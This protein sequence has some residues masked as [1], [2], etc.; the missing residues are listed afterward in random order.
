MRNTVRSFVAAATVGSATLGASAQQAVQWRVEDGGNGHW[1]AFN[2]DLVQWSE[3]RQRAIARGGDLVSLES[4][5]EL[6]WFRNQAWC[7]SGLKIHLG[8][9][10][11]AAA[12]SLTS[13]WRWLT[14]SA[15]NLNI[16]FDMDD[17]PCT[18][19]CCVEDGEQNLL[20]LFAGCAALGDVNNG[21]TAN[22]PADRSAHA[23]VIEWSSDCNND[24]LVDYGQILN[25]Q[26]ADA[27]D[28]GVPDMCEM[29]SCAG[30]VIPDGAI[31]GVD[32]AAV[33]SAWGTTGQGQ[34]AADVN[35]DGTVNGTDLSYILGGWGNC[36]T[37]PA[38]G[39]LL[40]LTPDPTVVTDAGLRG[41]I[42]STGY[43]WRVRDTATQIEMV[44]IPPG[45]FSMGCSPSASFTCSQDE[46]P[47]H[48]VTITHPFYLA[49]Y[50]VTQSQWTSVMGSNPSQ[51]QSASVHVPASQVSNRPVE[52]I[53]WNMAQGFLSVTGVR[54]PTEAE[55]EYAC[56]A[57]TTTAFHGFPG[58]ATGS[59]DD[60]LAG[61]IAWF[62]ANAASQTRP[63]GQRLPNS[64]GLHDMAGN[65]WEWVNDWYSDTYYAASPGT[66]P[67]GP[68]SGT[69]KVVRGASW[70]NQSDGCRSSD[71]YFIQPTSVDSRIGFR[72]ARN[73]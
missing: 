56:R 1:Y 21:P 32:L 7:A 18:Q 70:F 53:S 9:V 38:W 45:T 58:Y 64:L 62:S 6:N 16:P 15:V 14:G 46:L 66:N 29:P 26:L 36:I 52:R 61:A 44:L 33:L 11:D 55:W 19:G 42:A 40:E 13:G 17:S 57:G 49:R 5:A 68:V 63:V 22:C 24:G 69:H 2:A 28:N 30:D 10:Q 41:A 54:L 71:R 60:T 20:H 43:A 39:T 25:G 47:V 37:V 27:N 59:N 73:P 31:D 23:Y 48:S 67:F 12:S 3:A 50:E 51:F 4:S 35:R 72:V 34:F 65:V 8:G